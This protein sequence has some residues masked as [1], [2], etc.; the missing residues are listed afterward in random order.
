MVKSEKPRETRVIAVGN[1]KGGVGKT[2]NTVHLAAA[3]GELG[4]KCLVWDLD[5]N[6]GSTRHFGIP[7][8]MNVFGT[9]EVLTGQ[10]PPGEVIIR[11]GDLDGVVLPKGVHLLP[12]HTK[13]ESLEQV[14]ASKNVFMINQDV[15]LRPIAELRGEYDYIFLDTA[16]NLTTPTIAAYKAA[17]Y[18]LLSSIPE[19]FAME[20]LNNAVKYLQGAR[21]A[22]NPDLRLMGVIIGAVPGR[23]T[24]LARELLDYVERTFAA[25]DEFMRRFKTVIHSSTVVPTVQKSGT[26]LFDAEPGHKVTDQYRSLARELEE[27][28]MALD[29]QLKKTGKRRGRR[30]SNG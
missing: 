6:C 26:T 29:K 13:L 23:L 12:A 1:Q 4:R 15:L 7:D 3:L 27:R 5:V 2:T 8:G 14:L 25:G 18:F 30:T 20:G 28:F 16:P 21:E 17:Q 11:P 19:S 22:G 24:R 9:F 10:E